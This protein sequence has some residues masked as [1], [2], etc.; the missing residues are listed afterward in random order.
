R[1]LSRQP[2]GEPMTSRAADRLIIDAVRHG[3]GRPGVLAAAALLGAAADLLIPTALGRCVDTLVGGIAGDP[4]G[5]AGWT[6]ETTAPTLAVLALVVGSIACDT[7]VVLM[8]GV[9]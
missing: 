6:W 2:G 3:G 7:V 4:A 1:T 8:S 9:T 5:P